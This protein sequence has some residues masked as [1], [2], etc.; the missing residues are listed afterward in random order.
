MIITMPDTDNTEC[1]M[2]GIQVNH[3]DIGI[4]GALVQNGGNTTWP[5]IMIFL[6]ACLCEPLLDFLL[7]LYHA[8][9][10]WNGNSSSNITIRWL[11]TSWHSKN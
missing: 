11:I 4:A 6:H 5:S 2:M 1:S 7:Y 9:M 10:V 8:Y 3:G